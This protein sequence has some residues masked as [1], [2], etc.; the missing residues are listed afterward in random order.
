M[1]KKSGNEIWQRNLAQKITKKIIFSGGGI[2]S[3]QTSYAT[4]LFA[5]LVPL[6]NTSLLHP[7]NSTKRNATSAQ[8]TFYRLDMSAVSD[9][10][11]TQDCDS[12]SCLPT[13]HFQGHTEHASFA[14]ILDFVD[15]D[16]TENRKTFYT[17]MLPSFITDT[18]SEMKSFVQAAHLAVKHTPAWLPT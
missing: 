15:G 2:P 9:T 3:L 16:A 17:S 18:S 12:F 4:K 10:S 14:C 8:T 13:D 5:R 1:T 7:Q 6:S 11:L